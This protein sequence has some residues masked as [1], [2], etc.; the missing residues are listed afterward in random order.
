LKPRAEWASR[1]GCRFVAGDA[2]AMPLRPEGGFDLIVSVHALEHM[3]CDA[4]V[5]RQAAALLAR[6]GVGVFMVPSP[7]AFYLYGFHGFRGYTPRTFERL[8]RQAGLSLRTV[9]RQ[10]GL[11]SFMAHFFLIALP[12]IHL[13]MLG[14]PRLSLR[15]RRGFGRL[16]RA[17]AAADAVLPVGASSF[18]FIVAPAAPR[19]AAQTA[20][21]LVAE[22]VVAA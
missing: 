2:E 20:R 22:P 13:P 3:R 8:C 10:G 11:A 19:H 14:L 17:A 15:G 9:Y 12:E 16:L 5:V 21:E 18:A 7:A 4:E 6:D 1:D